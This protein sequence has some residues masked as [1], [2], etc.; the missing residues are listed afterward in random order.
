MRILWYSPPPTLPT[1]IGKVARYLTQGLKRRG[2]EIYI[3]N[4]FYAG[5]PIVID[6]IVHYSFYDKTVLPAIMDE[7][8]PD[9]VV[10]YGSIWHPSIN[11]I[12]R[13]FTKYD[14]KIL[15]Y[16]PIEF[17]SVSDFFLKSLIG[18]DHIATTSYYAKNVI[19]KWSSIPEDKVSV[20][21]H[22]VDT[23]IYRPLNPKPRFENFEDYFIFGMVARNQIRKEYPVL[24][25]AFASLPKYIKDECMLYLHTMPLEESGGKLGWNL[26]L[27]VRKYNLF[28]KV[29]FPSEKACKFMGY[30]EKEMCEIY[31]AMDVHCLITSGEGFGLPLIEA[32]A[33][34]IPQIASKNTCI[35]EIL[36]DAG[37]YAECWEEDLETVEG[38]TLS[39]TKISAVRECMIMLF[40]D[41]NLRKKLSQNALRRV[42]LFS[43]DRAVS[44]MEDAILKAYNSNKKLGLE[45]LRK[46]ERICNET[47]NEFFASFIPKGNGL[48]LDLG[49]GKHT[50][51]RKTIESRG[52]EYIGLDIQKSKRVTVVA[53]A[54]YLPFRDRA[55][56]FL[57]ANQ[58]LEHIDTNE[59]VKVLKEAMR[60]S[61]HG[62]FIFP[63][64]DN[65]S[66]WYN[67]DHKPYSNEI[68]KYIALK[69]LGN[70]II[71]W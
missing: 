53:D 57:F 8:K 19:L 65:E 13:L 45:I 56:N 31:N 2:Y 49:C 23:N 58:L 70:Y 48:C 71:V 39:T 63:S 68:R 51:Y 14:V 44:M 60:A 66:Y 33:C 46:K 29:L 7:V 61:K 55:F 21:Y 38:F 6:G 18:A 24:L 59:Q 4:E 5:K 27:L 41:K 16:A 17:S 69:S 43:W 36:G 50:L 28:G 62:V 12:T 11:Q 15:L 67:A 40:E 3:L 47:Y 37:I 54:R 64:E 34:G 1:G 52:Y 30:S 25:R 32:M 20:V 22:G 10:I 9:V 42:M 35:P 26:P